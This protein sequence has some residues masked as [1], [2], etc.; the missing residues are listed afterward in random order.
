MPARGKPREEHPELKA[1]LCYAVRPFVSEMTQLKASLCYAV[2]RPFVS[3]M[4]QFVKAAAALPDHLSST[5]GTHTEGKTGSCNCPQVH[6]PW[7]P[8]LHPV[9]YANVYTRK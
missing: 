2:V 3:E 1:S 9:I 5:P 7:L 6:A 8:D 4:T